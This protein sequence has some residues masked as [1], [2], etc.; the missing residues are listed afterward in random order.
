MY[1]L[2]FANCGPIS[3]NL[4]LFDQGVLPNYCH[5]VTSKGAQVFMPGN[6]HYMDGMHSST[7]RKDN[8][9]WIRLL[10]CQL[11]LDDQNCEIFFN[12]QTLYSALKDTQVRLFFKVYRFQKPFKIF[13]SVSFCLKKCHLSCIYS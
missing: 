2:L 3:K 7:V 10:D 12:K 1:F 6:Q 8:R 4:L 5:Q 13:K 11:T 9:F